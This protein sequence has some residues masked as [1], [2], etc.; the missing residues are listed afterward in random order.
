MRIA[1]H[2]PTYWP[3]LGLLDKIA[4]CDLFV[5]LDNVQVS[6]GS[7]QYRNQFLCNQSIKFVTLPVVI[8]SNTKFFEL[9]FKNI[10]WRENQLSYLKN[11]YLKAKY[12]NQIFPLVESI[13]NCFPDN[14][15]CNFI[16]ETMIKSI[17]W[18]GIDV[19]IKRASDFKF[20][21]SKGELV[22]EIC[23]FFEAD[24]YVSGQGAKQY[25]DED[26]LNKFKA[27]QINIEWQHFQHPKYYQSNSNGNFIE[28]LAGLDMLF[29]NGIDDSQKIFKLIL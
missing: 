8:N 25:M 2:Q 14:N 4:K 19:Q 18:L 1:I 11:Y 6:K 13:Y 17:E 10:H 29:H 22:Y 16:I 20:E 3:W 28:G 15:A 7:F 21:A 26:L 9:E 27:N 5:I 23:S 24:T 12:F